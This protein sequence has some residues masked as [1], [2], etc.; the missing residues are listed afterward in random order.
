[1]TDATRIYIAC[2]PEVA[3]AQRRALGWLADHRT[4]DRPCRNFDFRKPGSYA[5]AFSLCWQP[6]SI[7][8]SGDLGEMTITHWQAITDLQSSLKWLA[9]S[10]YDYLLGKARAVRV[11]DP[12]ATLTEV[13]RWANEEAIEAIRALRD[14]RPRRRD[15]DDAADWLD[16]R[17]DWL[18]AL[19]NYRKFRVRDPLGRD[20][21]TPDPLEY[22]GDI[23]APDGW[24]AWLRLLRATHC[25]PKAA[26]IFTPGGRYSIKTGLEAALSTESGAWELFGRLGFDEPL[27]VYKWSSHT[28]AQITAMQWGAGRALAWLEGE[29]A[30]SWRDPEPGFIAPALSARVDR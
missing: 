8:L 17:A 25:A 7:T 4:A 21:W 12:E 26:D 19:A 6:G 20:K 23:R 27:N 10:S 5:Y 14:E 30:Y 28:I 1:M 11:Y 24:E 13:V 9:G 3:E 2:D 22:H 15:F 16:A 18:D 29:S